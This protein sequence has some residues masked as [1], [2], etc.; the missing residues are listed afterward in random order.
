MCELVFAHWEARGREQFKE[1]AATEEVEVVGIDVIGVAEPVAGLTGAGP[2]ILNA[3]DAAA[4]HRDGCFG[5][6]A[7]ADDALMN[8][9]EDQVQRDGN[10]EPF[11]AERAASQ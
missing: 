1:T 4:V 5:A 3:G 9:G 10:P 8:P 7:G 6:G 2:A 11:R